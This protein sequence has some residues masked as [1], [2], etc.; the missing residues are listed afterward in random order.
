VGGAP[1]PESWAN[2]PFTCHNHHLVEF[3]L[4]GRL[5]VEANGVDVTPG[6]PKQRALLAL[7]LLR[8]GQVVAT[9][10]LVE[11]LWGLRP[12]ETAQIAL[13]GHISALRKWLGAERIE[14]RAPGYRL[15][16]ADED[17]F[18]IRRFERV[19]AGSRADG[20]A[21]RSQ[22]L[23]DGLALFR[24]E[25]LF[26]FRDEQ[27]ACL[28]AGRL[29]ELRLATLEDQIEADLE[30]GRHVEIVPELERLVAE[31][32]LRERLR[33]QLMLAL[34]GAGRQADALLSF[35]EGR[36]LLVDELGVDPGP[37]L[38]RLERQILNHDP[39]LAAP[40][41]FTPVLH[42]AKKRANLPPQP[43]SFVGRDREI[44]EVADLLRRSDVR[45]ITLTGPGGTGKTRLAIRVAADLHDDFADGVVFVGLAPLQDPDLVSTTAAQALGVRVTSGE[46]LEED[47]CRHI[48]TRKLLLV[49]DNFEHV[50]AAAPLVADIAATEADVKLLVTSRTPLRLS[51]EQIYPVSPLEMPVGDEGVERLLQ[52]KSVE[53]FETRARAV[54]PDFAVSSANAAAVADICRAL[55]GLPLAIELA[56][57]RLG[58]LPLTA[59]HERLD[60]RLKLLKGGARDSPER[61]RTLRATID[62]SYDLLEPATQRLFVRLAAFAG[63]WTV[64]AAQSI[65]G[66]G[67]DVIDGLASLT[68]MGLVRLEATDEQPRFTMLETIHEY[69]GERLESSKESLRL[70]RR[71]AKYFLALAEQAE[72][73]LFGIG[74]HTEW[75]DRLE[76]DQ[77]NLRTALDSLEASGETDSALRLAAALWRFWDMRGHLVEGRRR[78]AR[79]IRA[80]DRPTA[81]RAKALSG[82]ADMALT[83][84]DMVAGGRWA[85]EAL[86]LHRR[87]GDEWGIAFSLLMFAYA[88]GQGGDWRR[89]Q[90]LYDESADRFRRCGDQ[91]YA[92][93]ATRSLAWAYYEGGDL[94]RARGI[95][96]NNLR[97]AREMHDELLEGV[98]LGNLADYATDEGRFEEAISLLRESHRLLCDL[99][100]LLSIAACVC[101]LAR[102]LA[103]SDQAR[104]ATLVLA[105]AAVPLEEI[106]AR[107]PWL[108]KLNEQTLTAIRMQL[109]EIAFAEAWE[110]GQALTA[111]E[112]VALARSEPSGAALGPR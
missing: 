105:S 14:T 63:G 30:L 103:L 49:F 109:D 99:D 93:R 64:D 74:S 91:H 7:L 77:D 26:D 94:D 101:R 46:T 47:I 112:A 106:G 18:D 71:H 87:L 23:R 108:E 90:Q 16:L 19:A 57:R 85:E 38:K 12:P 2:A 11:A 33:A 10:D 80:D 21:A 36:A 29:A 50:L 37:A 95:T 84:G 110:Q 25:P 98:A 35:R 1:E 40:D 27:F 45:L 58:A 48:G 59:L 97:Q 9:D 66:E 56:A 102:A 42:L 53:L 20:P 65:C 28:E 69:V 70:H 89:A 107:P 22:T 34:Y 31:H 82:A 92:L 79:A 111:D 54:R 17:E 83:N 75:L 72:P 62:W 4:L 15:H 73:N 41:A 61:Q 32:P 76:R 60:H 88:V 68:D 6:R 52:C 5:E 39:R 43:T 3:R 86:A 55:D 24:G 51:A 67:L 78:L 96:E 100:D 44:R 13:Y 81:A 104:T 8:E